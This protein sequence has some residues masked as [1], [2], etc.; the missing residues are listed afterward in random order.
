MPGTTDRVSYLEAEKAKEAEKKAEEKKA[1]TPPAKPAAT[2]PKP[3][4]AVSAFSAEALKNALPQTKKLDPSVVMPK[5]AG[6]GPQDLTPERKQFIEDVKAVNPY[7]WKK[8]EP[9]AEAPPA[10]KLAMGPLPIKSNVSAGEAMP[11]KPVIQEPPAETAPAAGETQEEKNFRKA[12][13]LDALQAFAA[14]FVG[15]EGSYAKQRD[16]WK[17]QQA[18]NAEKIAAE[19][20]QLRMLREQARLSGNEAAMERYDRALEGVK[21]RNLRRELARAELEAQKGAAGASGMEQLMA[22][23]MGRGG[24]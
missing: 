20:A 14:G 21:D 15:R 18:E 2:Q 1:T 6:A 11:S 13:I 4:A 8:D 7:N 17:A 23:F 10:E 9:P 12:G 16:A 24:K 3:A 22:A 19:Q 5:P